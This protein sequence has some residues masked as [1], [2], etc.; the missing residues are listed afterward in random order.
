MTWTLQ[1]LR[2]H[3][4]E[5]DA[6][7]RRHRV[8]SLMVIG[9]VARGDATEH[10]DVDFVARFEDGFSLMDLGEFIMDMEDSLCCHVDVLSEKALDSRSMHRT[11]AEAVAL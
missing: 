6:I 10:S 9:S 5:I 11:M 8:I 2:N 4:T 1:K 3:K 7:A